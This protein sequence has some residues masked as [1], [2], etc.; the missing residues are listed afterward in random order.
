M[1]N[2]HTRYRVHEH[3]EVFALVN[4]VFDRKYATFNTFADI[5]GLSFGNVALTDP[6]SVSPAP[7]L[8]GYTGL[9][10]RF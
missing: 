9:R 3:L 8:A 10:F 6:R 1:V 7:P 5:A 4:N 2:I